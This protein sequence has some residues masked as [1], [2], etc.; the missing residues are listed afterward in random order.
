[1]NTILIPIKR[2]LSG[3]YTNAVLSSANGRI[4]TGSFKIFA[5]ECVKYWSLLIKSERK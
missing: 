1:M 5:H 4:I 3:H 2:L